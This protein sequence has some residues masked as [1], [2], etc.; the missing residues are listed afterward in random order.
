MRDGKWK[1]VSLSGNAWELYD[2][3]ADPTELH[4]LLAGHPDRAGELAAQWE[5]W[6]RR[7]H[8]D[9]T[10]PVGDYQAPHPLKGTGANVK[11][12]AE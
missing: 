9:T 1:L 12:V 10:T 6:A 4:D 5:A 2:L 3:E 7:C 11:V 8:V